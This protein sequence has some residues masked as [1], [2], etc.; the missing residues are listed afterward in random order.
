MEKLKKEEEEEIKEEIISDDGEAQ[1]MCIEAEE[2]EFT[3]ENTGSGNHDDDYFD[4]IAGHLQDIVFDDK[5]TEV[6][7]KCFAANCEEF[8]ATEENKMVYTEV[9]QNYKDT[10]ESYIEKV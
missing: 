2:K 5:F 1:E 7:Q 6:Q 9:F 8:D 3:I 4:M 10:I